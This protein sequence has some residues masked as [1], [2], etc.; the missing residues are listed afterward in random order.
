MEITYN[1]CQSCGTSMIR[2]ERGLG[3]TN[4]DGSKSLT[5]CSLCFAGGAFL[6]PDMTVVQMQDQVRANMKKVG[7][8]GFLATV[9]TRRIPRLLRWCAER[10]RQ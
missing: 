8:S 5:Y 7:I 4:T 2:D 10:V 6:L 3:G 9:F 1:D